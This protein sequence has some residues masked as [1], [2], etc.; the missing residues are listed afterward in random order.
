MYKTVQQI[1]CVWQQDT[2]AATENL[3]LPV[4]IMRVFNNT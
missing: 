4:L 2:Y 1:M 3:L